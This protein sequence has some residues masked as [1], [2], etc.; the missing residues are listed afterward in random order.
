MRTWSI[1]MNSYYKTASYILEEGSWWVFA[2]EETNFWVDWVIGKLPQLI[3]EWWWYK[4]FHPIF[5][6]CNGRK[7]TWMVDLD[8]EV[9]RER[10]PE[11]WQEH[12]DFEKELEEE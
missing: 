12:L 8:F 7:K 5:Q 10:H 9:V 6:W 4:V 1:G 11:R 3:R 2:I